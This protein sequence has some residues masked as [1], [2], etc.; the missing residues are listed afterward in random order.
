[1]NKTK[2]LALLFVL[3]SAPTAMFADFKEYLDRIEFGP[4][5]GVGFYMGQFHP[6]EA[7]HPSLVRIQTYDALGLSVNEKGHMGWPGIETFGFQ[8]GY[9][10]NMRWQ[11]QVKTIRQRV[12]YMEFELDNKK[13]CGL[14]YNSMW[15]VDVM[16]EYNLLYYGNRMDI[17]AKIYNVVPYVGFGIGCTMYN[18]TATLRS[19]PGLKSGD[20]NTMFPMV[21]K[22]YKGKDVKGNVVVEDGEIGVGLYVPVAFGVKWRVNDNV[23]LVGSV[24]YNLY[25][26]GTNPGGL[27]SNLGGATAATYYK[28]SGDLSATHPAVE[29]IQNRPTFDQLTKKVVGAGDCLFSISAIF[30]LERWQEERLVY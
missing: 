4:M 11:L 8:A 24:Q 17:D 10:F 30:N 13:N 20:I 9:R 23:Q 7:T 27:S 28:G 1:M 25:L 2:V 15:H 21:G 5:M 22:E 12:N 3:L 6:A 16:A 18:K 26:S 19:V 14:Y 29:S